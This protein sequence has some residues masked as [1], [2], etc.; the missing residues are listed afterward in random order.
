MWLAH[1]GQKAMIMIQYA[2]LA[3]LRLVMS[4]MLSLLLMLLALIMLLMLLK[5]GVSHG[6][7]VL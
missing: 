3:L 7:L 4:A 2:D 5:V 1:P 6:T